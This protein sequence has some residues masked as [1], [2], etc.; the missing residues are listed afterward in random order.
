MLKFIFE[1]L[2]V[3]PLVIH[4]INTHVFINVPLLIQIIVF[5]IITYMHV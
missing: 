1:F 3:L 5:C 2:K 4:P